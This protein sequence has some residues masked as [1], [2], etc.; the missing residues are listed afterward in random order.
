MQIVEMDSN[1]K[2]ITLTMLSNYNDIDVR[3]VTSLNS[4][5]YIYALVHIHF[6]KQMIDTNRKIL[7]LQCI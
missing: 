4:T 7:L 6:H 2:C 3:V 1:N 5:I